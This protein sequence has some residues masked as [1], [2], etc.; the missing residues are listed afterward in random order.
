MHRGESFIFL[1]CE[2][3]SFNFLL[4]NIKCWSLKLYG[5]TF[6]VKF[7]VCRYDY[8]M[9]I[10]LKYKPKNKKNSSKYKELNPG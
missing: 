5:C 10:M 3:T 9:Q 2:P 8:Y 6:L 4:S 7:C 1:C